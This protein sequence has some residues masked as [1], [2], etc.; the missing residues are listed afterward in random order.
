VS[1]AVRSYETVE[2]SRTDGVTEIRFHTDGGPLVW[3]ATAH[4]EAGDVFAEIAGDPETK[5]VIVTG[6]G[7]SF[8]VDIDRASFAGR[9]SWDAIWWEGKRLLRCLLDIDVPVLGALN[10]PAYIH[11]EIPLLADIVVAAD[12]ASLA[13]KAHVSTGSVPGDGAHLVWPYLLGAR[14]AK[15]FLLMNQEIDAAEALRLGVVNEVVPAADVSSRVWEIARDLAAKPLPFLRYTRETL[16]IVE[17]QQLL[18]GLS[19][20]LALEGISFA[21]VAGLRAA[22]Q[23]R[24]D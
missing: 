19:H 15:Y 9:V 23:A 6:T 3:S 14:R 8:C 4:R 11:A 12:T 13:D 10:G 5:V 17:R 2:L 7:E 20:G 21:D 1:A 24:G 16:N 18:A 22:E